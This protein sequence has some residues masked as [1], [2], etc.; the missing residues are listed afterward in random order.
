MLFA[1]V[2]TSKSCVEE[3]GESEEREAGSGRENSEER[4][5]EEDESGHTRPSACIWGST[6]DVRLSAL[7]WQMSSAGVE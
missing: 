4:K 1:S 7:S 5:R 3:R 2:L 6:R